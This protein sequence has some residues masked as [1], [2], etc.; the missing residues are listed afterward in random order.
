LTINQY[1]IQGCVDLY[2]ICV[3]NLNLLDVLFV[4]RYH[5]IFCNLF[6]NYRVF[7]RQALCGPAEHNSWPEL[8]KFMYMYIHDIVSYDNL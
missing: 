6:F 4:P 1:Q 7:E 8:D 2:T 3:H 5:R